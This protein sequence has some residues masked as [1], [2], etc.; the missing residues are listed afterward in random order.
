[1]IL[2]E[3]CVTIWD[4]NVEVVVRQ[5]IGGVADSE[6]GLHLVMA[7]VY[8]AF[9]AHLAPHLVS[10]LSE[11]TG[12]RRQEG[13][14]VPLQVIGVAFGVGV[15][16]SGARDYLAARGVAFFRRDVFAGVRR[17]GSGDGAGLGD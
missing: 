10:W 9:L 17:G 6:R 2:L 7:V 8:G 13:V 3:V 16:A 5:G 1:L 15:L 11:P 12:F 4:F 14:P